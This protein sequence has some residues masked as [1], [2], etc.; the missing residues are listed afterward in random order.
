MV[1]DRNPSHRGVIAQTDSGSIN[2]V[3]YGRRTRD[4]PSALPGNVRWFSVDQGLSDG[5]GSI[6]ESFSTA[7]SQGYVFLASR[8]RMESPVFQP[9]TEA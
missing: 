1:E 3:T 6:V 2:L 9:A 4:T 5:D 8:L 7:E